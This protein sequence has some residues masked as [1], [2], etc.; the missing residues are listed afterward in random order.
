MFQ[1]VRSFLSVR[2]CIYAA[3]QTSHLNIK[4]NKPEERHSKFKKGLDPFATNN[5]KKGPEKTA[6]HGLESGLY[7]VYRSLSKRAMGKLMVNV[8]ELKADNINFT[9]R[10]NSCFKQLIEEDK[11]RICHSCD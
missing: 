4:S 7:F 10:R 5:L 6:N 2:F 11:K 3:S 9:R 1:L 8:L